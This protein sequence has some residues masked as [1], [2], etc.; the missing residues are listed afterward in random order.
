[1]AGPGAPPARPVPLRSAPLPLSPRSVPPCPG[2]AVGAAPPPSPPGSDPRRQIRRRPLR[3]IVPGASS[4]PSVAVCVPD[5][6][7]RTNPIA[8]MSNVLYACR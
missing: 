7:G 1:M 5:T 8:F 6:S 2:D 4:F 3:E